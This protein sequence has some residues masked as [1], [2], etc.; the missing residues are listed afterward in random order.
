MG[1]AIS[2][3]M[4]HI[5][6]DEHGSSTEKNEKNWPKNTNNQS[7]LKYSKN[8]HKRDNRSWYPITRCEIT[9]TEICYS[10]YHYP[11]DILRR[12]WQLRLSVLDLMVIKSSFGRN[13]GLIEHACTV[14]SFK[15]K[16]N[17]SNYEYHKEIGDHQNCCW[18]L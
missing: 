8:W 3:G 5:I 17:V 6:W 1:W 14:A 2:Y 15:G 13:P 18:R 7:S 10:H 16:Y 9:I 12:G 4:A 11:E